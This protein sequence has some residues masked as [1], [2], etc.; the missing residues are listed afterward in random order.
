M[1]EE[2]RAQGFS[3]AAEA[4]VATVRVGDAPGTSS[5]TAGA[6]LLLDRAGFLVGVDCRNEAGR[7][8]IVMLGPH[9][10]VERTLDARVEVGEA[11]GE[12]VS[13]TIPRARAAVRGHE[14]NPYV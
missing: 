10:A 11:G 2:R 5:R 13:V 7:G 1:L 4:D 6:Q 8:P 14:K 3:Y 12:V 9:E